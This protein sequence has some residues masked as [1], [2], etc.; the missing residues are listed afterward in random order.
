MSES[1]FK[2]PFC[3]FTVRCVWNAERTWGVSG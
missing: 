3:G 1:C 2:M